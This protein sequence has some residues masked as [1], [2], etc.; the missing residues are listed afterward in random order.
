KYCK[1]GEAYW[2]PTEVAGVDAQEVASEELGRRIIILRHRVAERPEAGG[3]VLLEVP[4][5]RFHAMGTNLP[6]SWSV[7]AVWRRYKG[8]AESENRLRE[9]GGQFGLKG[10]CCQKFAATQAV[11]QLAI[12]AYNLCV[13]LQRELGLLEKVQLQ[14]LRWRLFCRAAV[15]SRAQGQPTLK[16]AVQ[17][18]EQRQWWMELIE[19]LKSWLPPFNCNAVELGTT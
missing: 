2:T 10:F 17:D 15:W 11:C 1:H 16:L 7:L 6:R 14:T 4:G 9:L 3:K 13:L 12:W 18:Q 5:Y 19:K 8:R